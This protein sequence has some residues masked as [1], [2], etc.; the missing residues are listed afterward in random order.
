MVEPDDAGDKLLVEVGITLNTF[1]HADRVYDYKAAVKADDFELVGE[2]GKTYPAEAG[3]GDRFDQAMSF[4]LGVSGG[5]WKALFPPGVEPT[6]ATFDLDSTRVASGTVTFDGSGGVE[7]SVQFTDH[8][9]A[10]RGAPGVRGMSAFGR[11]T[12][13]SPEG[14]ILMDYNGDQLLVTFP[15]QGAGFWRTG[16][17]RHDTGTGYVPWARFRGSL[18]FDAPAD[19]NYQLRFTG[20]S[21]SVGGEVAFNVLQDR[22]FF[23]DLVGGQAVQTRQ[24]RRRP[25]RQRRRRRRQRREQRHRRLLRRHDRRPRQNPGPRRPFR[26]SPDRHRL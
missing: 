11:L 1:R 18:V 4:N 16:Q 19:Q 3:L 14:P 2:D 15:T 9:V 10:S 17:Y 6:S 21:W 20:E 12:V 26:P 8:V 24:E 13:D 7:G 22:Q 25:I 23:L 5:G